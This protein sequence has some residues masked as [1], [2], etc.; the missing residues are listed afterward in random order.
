M[1]KQESKKLTVEYL[2]YQRRKLGII[3]ILLI[4]VLGNMYFALRSGVAEMTLHNLMETLAGRGTDTLKIVVWNIRL[5]R[6]V[7]AVVAGAA[8]GVSGC[9]MQNNLK[10][11]L[12]SPSTLG[13]TGA[14]AFGANVAIILLGGGSLQS[15]QSDSVFILSPYLVTLCAFISSMVAIFAILVL[16]K[17]KAF[18]P[19][20]MILAGVAISSLFG[21]GTTFLQYFA[22]SHHVAA[23]VFWTF[24]NLGR[25]TWKE[26][27]ILAILFFLSFLYFM[28]KSWDYNAMIG[29]EDSAKSLGVNTQRVRMGSMF[30]ASVL[31]SAAVSFLGMISFIGLIAPQVTRRLIGNDHRYLIPSSALMGSLLLLV[32]DTVART[33]LSPI[34]LPVGVITSFLGAPI[35]LYI[36]VKDSNFLRS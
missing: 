35:F 6:I 24:G 1:D 34:V 28:L 21:A 8:L 19:N 23:A 22:E 20:V 13:V 29:G 11:P 7:A 2:Q 33:L 9:I 15:S 32:A 18:H 25:A 31:I 26:L 12:A 5:P 10:N 14:A 27:M 36:L 17:I 16:S 30:F 3:L 4:L